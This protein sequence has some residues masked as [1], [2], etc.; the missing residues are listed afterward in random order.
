MFKND[1]EREEFWR[2][3]SMELLNK[4]NEQELKLAKTKEH[5][6]PIT[7]ASVILA[8]IGWGLYFFG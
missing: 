2:H 3:I 1:K 4:V 7:L 6:I 5:L 8:V